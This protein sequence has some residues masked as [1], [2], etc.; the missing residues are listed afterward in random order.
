MEAFLAGLRDVDVDLAGRCQDGAF[1]VAVSV[2]DAVI[3]A[4]VF[5][6]A[7]VVILLRAQAVF[8]NESEGVEQNATCIFLASSEVR[9][10]KSLKM[11]ANV[12]C[13]VCSVMMVSF[14]FGF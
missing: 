9:L 12:V 4:V 14:C 6:A 3:R 7:E 1:L 8:D 2:V 11:S 5:L 10:S 13:L